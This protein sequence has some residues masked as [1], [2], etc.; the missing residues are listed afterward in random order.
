MPPTM[1]FDRFWVDEWPL[2]VA[3]VAPS[4]NQAPAPDGVGRQRQLGPRRH[5]MADA[6][7]QAPHLVDGPRRARTDAPSHR[8]STPEPP[9]IGEVHFSCFHSK[10][11]GRCI[12]WRKLTRFAGPSR[13]P[14]V[15]LDVFRQVRPATVNALPSIRAAGIQGAEA[16]GYTA[17][18]KGH[19][20]ALV[21]LPWAWLAARK[22]HDT[23]SKAVS[24]NCLPK[25]E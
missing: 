9:S 21:A 14:L 25:R 20:R 12:C 2:V 8:F 7:Q 10:L 15:R 24:S 17:Q 11:R 5:L 13:F 6:A 23:C 16:E 22:P 3:L 19:R 18:N 1:R 4:Q